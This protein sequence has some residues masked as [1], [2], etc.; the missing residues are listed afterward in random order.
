MRK[1]ELAQ[2]QEMLKARKAILI[3]NID[4]S[5]TNISDFKN[6]ECKDDLDYAEMSS[7]SYKE[8]QIVNH[9]KC[10]LKEIDEAL[11][12]IE[13]DEYGICEMCDE[14]IVIDR[15]KAKPFAKFC[16]PCREIYEKEQ[17]N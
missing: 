9:Q 16:I 7:D 3:S 5:V 11:E 17:N 1:K 12:K 2:L 10:E 8:E 6:Q 15:L 4:N 14:P 13:S